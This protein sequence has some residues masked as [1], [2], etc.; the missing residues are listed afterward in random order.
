MSHSPRA[1]F[2]YEESSQESALVARVREG[3]SKAFRIL[4]ERYMDS[5]TRF[6]FYIVHSHDSADDIAQSV[7]VGMWQYRQT[8]DPVRPLK[9]YL[10]RA[11]RN[12]A[13]NEKKSNAV[14][15]AYAEQVQAEQDSG[16]IIAFEPS[17]EGLILST[18][19]VQHALEQ[20]SDRRRLALRLRLEDEMTHNEIAQVLDISYEAA[21]RLVGRALAELQ[22]ILVSR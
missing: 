11:T 19:A 2:D 10:F 14:R 12:R 7:F 9:P 20:L 4:V 5:V 16:S 22:K 3:D 13:L 18:S 15:N 1:D 17:P 21:K 8:L 6:A